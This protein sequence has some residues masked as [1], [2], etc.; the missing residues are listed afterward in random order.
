MIEKISGKNYSETFNQRSVSN[1]VYDVHNISPKELDKLTL[2]MFKNGE[3]KLKDRLPFIPLDTKIEGK[4]IHVKYYSRVWDNKD[5]KRDM[6]MEYTKIL[7]E[8]ISDNDSQMNIIFTKEALALLERI[9]KKF[10]FN[11]IL[12][13]QIEKTS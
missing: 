10:S 11:E 9:D 13:S 3:I 5:M 6:I 7:Q 8:Q 4:N 12:A 1:T 2:Q